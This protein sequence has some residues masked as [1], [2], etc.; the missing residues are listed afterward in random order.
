VAPKG[1]ELE[2][3]RTRLATLVEKREQGFRDE[4][5]HAGRVFL[6]VRGVLAQ[7]HEA[8]ATSV[9]PRRELLPSIAC[10][11]RKRREIEIKR[12]QVFIQEYREA[13]REFVNGAREVL[14]PFGTY[15]MLRT[16]RVRCHSPPGDPAFA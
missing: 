9:E 12:L 6:G 11:N 5:A 15:R 10:K 16:Y 13:L 1:E 2:E 14:F 4:V 3:Y 7:S 8:K